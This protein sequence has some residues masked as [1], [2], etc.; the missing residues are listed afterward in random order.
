MATLVI[1]NVNISTPLEVDDLGLYLD[2]T[3]DLDLLLNFRDEDLIESIDLE[4][5]INGDGQVTLNGTISMTYQNVIDYLTKISHYDVVDY[6]YITS[7]DSIT[8]ITSNELEELSDGSETTIHIHDGRYYTESE[9]NTSGQSSIHW[10]NII[11][12]PDFGALQWRNSVLSMIDGKGLTTAMNA[13]SATEGDSWWNTSNDHL[14]KYQSSVWVDQGAPSE[15]DRIIFRDGAGSDDKIYTYELSSWDSGI[16]PENNWALMVDDDGDLKPAQY[17]YDSSGSPNWI[18]IADVDWYQANFI[19]VVPAGNLSSANVQ[20]A[21][22]E[23]QTDINVINAIFPTIDI[24]YTYNNGSTI[25]VDSTNV[26]WNMSDGRDFIIASDSGSTEIFTTAASGSG[27]IVTINGNLDVNGGSITLDGASNSNFS[28]TSANLT[29]STLTSGSIELNSIDTLSFKDQYLTSAINL[30]ET[31]ETALNSLFS[32]TSIIGAINELEAANNLDSVYDSPLGSGS[33]RIIIVDNGA[34]KL[35][36]TSSTYAPLELVPL[37]TVPASG[38]APGQL[39]VFGDYLYLY[40]DVRNKFLSTTELQFAFGDKAVDGRLLS[41][42]NNK[43]NMVGYK[44]PRDATIVGVLAN[45]NKGNLNKSLE[46]RKNGSSTSI[47]S[48]SLSSG[49]YSNTTVNV[50]VSVN[51]I[52][53]LYV[54]SVGSSAQELVAQIFVKWRV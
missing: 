38:L 24:D 9:L 47:F 22:E 13:F 53:Q 21:L 1:K 42:G 36:A 39:I 12:A 10:D 18:K 19:E 54:S 40:D 50:D 28:V 32:S 45:V 35:N 27:D 16:I 43:G 15:D 23:L 17:V 3:E 14:Y 48:F 49:S 11:N 41:I 51:D 34:V 46:V 2:A 31:G 37:S 30:S 5:A 26:V 33:G 44:V 8:D 4:T 6:A 7:E 29:I 52:V 20:D 25:I